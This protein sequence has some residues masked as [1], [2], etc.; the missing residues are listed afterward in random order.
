MEEL[1]KILKI[2]DKILDLEHV[3]LLKIIDK[4]NIYDYKE[5]I[6]NLEFKLNYLRIN[7]YIDSST[8]PEI[9]NKTKIL[10]TNID[11]NKAVK[12]KYNFK[13]LHKKLQNELFILTGKKQK[14]ISNK[15]SFLPNFKDLE[16]KL[17]KVS[18]KYK[19]NDWIKIEKLLLKYIYTCHKAN[20]EYISLMEYYIEKNNTS[21]LANDYMNFL[22]EN[23][24]NEVKENYDGVN[25]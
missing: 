17:L 23:I 4:Y 24:E 15:Y 12:V 11:S 16:I 2:K 10:F 1:I 14:V 9:T 22:I 3:F 21:K 20:W 8:I 6:L 18:N 5:Y 7:G 19:L 13:E 25:I